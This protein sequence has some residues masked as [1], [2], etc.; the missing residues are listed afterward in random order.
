MGENL[1]VLVTGSM[2]SGTSS[3]AGSLK[4][5]GLHVPQPEVPASPRN[6]K[7]HFEPHWVIRFHKRLLRQALTRPSD[8]SPKAERRVAEAIEVSGAAAELATWLAEQTEPRLVIKDPHAAWLVGTWAQAAEQAGRDLRLLTAL[9]HPAEVVGSQDLT[10]GHRRDDDMRRIKET[11]NVAA[12]LNV[13]LVTERSGRGLRRSFI[14][15]QDLIEDWR[16]SLGRVSDQLDLGLETDPDRAGHELDEWLDP[17]LRR[18]QISWDDIVVP[19]WLR[20]LA[21]QTWNQLNLLVADPED[22]AAMARLDDIRTDYEARYAEAAALT[23]DEARHRERLGARNSAAKFRPRVQKQKRR[24]ERAEALALGDS[25]ESGDSGQPIRRA[26]GQIRAR[27][28]SGKRDATN[29]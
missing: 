28:R 13:A 21:E 25:G 14:G 29:S 1:A 22:P 15:Y 23:L 19:A 18:S 7:G 5:L 6:P 24:A 17:S 26:L 2:R 16:A 20:D 12:W 4:T 10:W 11:S 3:L 27:S 8:G 9:R